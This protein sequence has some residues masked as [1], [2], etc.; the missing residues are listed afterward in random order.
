MQIRG[1]DSVLNLIPRPRSF[2][3]S[4]QRLNCRPP[5]NC[6]PGAGQSLQK[7]IQHHIKHLLG[8]RLLTRQPE[9]RRQFLR[10]PHPQTVRNIPARTV[11]LI[12]HRNRRL[13]NPAGPPVHIKLAARKP[14]QI[15]RV[16]RI[17]QQQRRIPRFRRQLHQ[18]AAWRL[19]QPRLEPR[20]LRY[21][22]NGRRI[23]FEQYQF[24]SACL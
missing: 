23:Q 13:H 6:Y 16:R 8:K 1:S 11:P 10:N 15:R 18:N 17:E 19:L 3:S 20:L 5:A 24:V 2:R 9:T 4:R 12:R 21:G 14:P 22:M 7:I